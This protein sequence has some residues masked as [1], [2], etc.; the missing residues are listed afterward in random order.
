MSRRS[1]L[2]VAEAK[3]NL[4]NAIREVEAGGSVVITRYGRPVAALVRAD[5]LSRIERLRAAGPA[6]GLASIAGG[7]EGSEELADALHTSP[8]RGRREVASLDP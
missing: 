2:S 6:Q 5:D 3:A 1:A 4:S 7:W 8:R